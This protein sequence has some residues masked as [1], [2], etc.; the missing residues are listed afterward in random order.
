MSDLATSDL[1]SRCSSIRDGLIQAGLFTPPTDAPSSGTALE[2]TQTSWRIGLNPLALSSDQLTFFQELG[3]QLWRFCR[4]VNRLYIESVRGTQPA[5]VASWLDQ[6]KPEALVTYSRM[7][8]FRD[9][10]PGVIRPDVIPTQDGMV[11]TELDS[12]PGGIGLTACMSQ[13]SAVRQESILST[14]HSSGGRTVSWRASLRCCG[15]T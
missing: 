14:Q 10:L 3:P 6:G 2:T 11:I 9:D 13:Q 12:V 8:R 1:L 7:K 5:W 4:A 15:I